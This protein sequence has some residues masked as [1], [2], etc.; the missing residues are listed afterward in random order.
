[1]APQ[2]SRAD[3]AQQLVEPSAMWTL[4][5]DCRRLRLDGCRMNHLP[6]TVCSLGVAQLFGM[7]CANPLNLGLSGAEVV[8]RNKFHPVPQPSPIAISRRRTVRFSPPPASSRAT[9]FGIWSS[10][11][12]EA[13]PA[14]VV[15]STAD[16]IHLCP[17]FIAAIIRP[18]YLPCIRID[19]SAGAVP[20]T[21]IAGRSTGRVRP[22]VP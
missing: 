18:A 3:H 17:L 9:S 5:C 21:E 6:G 20:G 19:S 10:D 15:K 14:T 16:A 12:R 4:G 22:L 11:G 13:H 7:A 2:L 8:S 1:M